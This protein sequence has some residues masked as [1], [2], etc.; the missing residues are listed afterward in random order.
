MTLT[1]PNDFIDGGNWRLISDEIEKLARKISLPPFVFLQQF[2][3]WP[4]R[5]MP[6][7]AICKQVVIIAGVHF[8]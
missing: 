7:G 3:K 5:D 6:D 1:L 8:E 4:V 2:L